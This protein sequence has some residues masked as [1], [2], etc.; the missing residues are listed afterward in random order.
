M[1]IVSLLYKITALNRSRNY[2]GKFTMLAVG[3]TVVRHQ[4]IRT[5]NR[6]NLKHTLAEICSTVQHVPAAFSRFL[7][8]YIYLL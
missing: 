5:C 2:N 6:N 1:V 8:D 3:R 7:L 4:M